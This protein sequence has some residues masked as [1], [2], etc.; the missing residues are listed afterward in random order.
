MFQLWMHSIHCYCIPE[1]QKNKHEINTTESEQGKNRCL[2]PPVV[3]VGSHKDKLEPTEGQQV[4]IEYKFT[5]IKE[6][7]L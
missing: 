1:E 5:H 6:P 4:L 2:E 7:F 3:L